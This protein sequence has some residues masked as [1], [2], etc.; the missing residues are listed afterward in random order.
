MRPFKKMS[1]SFL[2]KSGGSDNNAIPNQD[3][4]G[5]SRVRNQSW[6]RTC[7]LDRQFG[8]LD[9]IL[10]SLIMEEHTLGNYV[11]DSFTNLTWVRIITLAISTLRQA[12]TS[13]RIKLGIAS[14]F[15]RE[16]T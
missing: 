14:R 13:R 9:A 12:R 6:T 10:L 16:L 4:E 8:I 1:T 11:N 2:K 3:I 5:G 7:K 15:S